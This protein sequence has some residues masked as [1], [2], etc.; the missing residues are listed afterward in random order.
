MSQTTSGSSASPWTT[1]ALY[2]PA[3]AQASTLTQVKKLGE[4]RIQAHQKGIGKEI[5]AKMQQIALQ[6]LAVAA[7]PDAEKKVILQ[8]RQDVLEQE[9]HTL[10][11]KV[12]TA[13]NAPWYKPHTAI[14]H[15]FSN[16]MSSISSAVMKKT[17]TISVMCNSEPWSRV[18]E[19]LHDVFGEGVFHCEV[20]D[21]GNNAIYRNGKEMSYSELTA[22][23]KENVALYEEQ[24]ALAE[25]KGRPYRGYRS[26]P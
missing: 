20:D 8:A 12:Q 7:E 18:A 22:Y 26:S 16:A 24:F 13:K 1:S 19:K 5:D 4:H 23:A 9:L 2:E 21:K 17:F 15:A 25:E 10:Q 14:S 6:K 11:G 3:S